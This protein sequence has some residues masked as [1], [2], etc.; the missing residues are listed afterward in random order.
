MR[1]PYLVLLFVLC[2][3]LQAGDPADLN[4]AIEM[5]RSPRAAVRAEGSK[6]ADKELRKLLAPLLEAMKDQDTEVRRRVR[7]AILGLV[8]DHGREPEKK[9]NLANVNRFVNVNQLVGKWVFA[10]QLGLKL[11]LQPAAV[12]GLLRPQH[13]VAAQMAL[14]HLG[15]V[16]RFVAVPKRGTGFRVIKV[17]RNSAAAKVGLIAGDT[18]LTINKQAVNSWQAFLKV[19][20]K[21]RNFVGL[22]L[23]GL[24][25]KGALEIAVK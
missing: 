4:R 21:R 11:K 23:K 12:A 3:P 9:R 15:L 6:L 24:R 20:G 2:L 1:A 8:P 22:T 13:E 5:F 14:M 19:M 17:V 25:G 18:I 7:E 10:P 16:G